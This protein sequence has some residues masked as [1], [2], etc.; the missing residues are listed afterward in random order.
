MSSLYLADRSTIGTLLAD[1]PSFRVDQL[2]DGL[3]QR[4]APLDDLT[5]L[6]AQLRHRLGEALPTAL[7]AVAETVSP[8][9]R[10]VKWLWRLHDGATIETVLMHYDDRSTV[11][12]SSQAGCAMGCG[13]CATGQS[14]FE[15]HLDTGEIVEQVVR[16]IWRARPRR[17][18]NIVFMGMGEPLAN[19]DAVW[20]AV[21]RIH[22]DLGISARHLTISTVGIVPGIRRLADEALPV[23]L[24]VSL[25]AAN[26][27]LRDELVP[28]NRRYPL[29]A[30]LEAC[31]D[32]LA[33]KN[34]R[35]SFEWALIDGVNDRDRDALELA[36]LARS[37]RAHINLIPLNP[38]PGYAVRGTPPAR[39]RSFRDHL[40]ELGA[41]ATIRQNRGTEIDAACGQLRTN[42][43]ISVNAPRRR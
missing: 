30:L 27:A 6:P 41:N 4:C 34:R 31:A 39:V 28:I 17:V 1:E 32:H 38:T 23:N 40:A 36:D 20:A 5:N 12:V 26:D 11:C 43:E 16:S 14:G 35:L 18:S 29:G 2:W 8:D 9:Q 7:E 24:A 15:R 33:A 22:G 13:F 25:H 10:T 42:H 19:Y 3:Y 37:L 21:E